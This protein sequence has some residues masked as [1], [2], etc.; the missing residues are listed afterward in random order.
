MEKRA[1]TEVPIHELLER[2][3]SPRAFAKRSIE[4]EKLLSIFEAARWAASASN[5]QPWSFLVATRDDPK[6][7]EAMLGVLI[8]FNQ[9][10]AHGA[11]ALILTVAHT[12]F[13]KDGKPNRHGFYDLGQAAANLAIQATASGLMVHP[14]AGFDVEAARGRFAVPAGWEP[15]S[16]IAV[17]YP[18]DVDSL[19]ERLRAREIAP[20]QRKPIETFVFSGTWG[21]P[22]LIT[23]SA[24]S[25]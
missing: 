21:H 8:E 16:M 24:E 14:M 23:G 9:A 25:K 7:F 1:E 5:E 19:S 10:W 15:V 3:W 4:R 11:A 22:A 20:R 17:G 2:R 18:G 12:Q 6:N 13:E